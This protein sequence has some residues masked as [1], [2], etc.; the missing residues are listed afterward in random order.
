M[1]DFL[2]R[3]KIKKQIIYVKHT[4]TQ[5]TL[6][7]CRDEWKYT[8]EIMEENKVEIQEEKLQML[9]LYVCYL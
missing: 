3:L 1:T 4:L 9:C 5:N 7:F 8:L 6:L 2:L